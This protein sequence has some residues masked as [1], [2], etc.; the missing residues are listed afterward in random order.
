[1]DYLFLALYPLSSVLVGVLAN[2]RRRNPWIW[3]VIG[4]FL[5]FL[6]LLILFVLPYGKCHAC[7]QTAPRKKGLVKDVA[8]ES[9]CPKC[10]QAINKLEA[11]PA[12]SNIRLWMLLAVVVALPASCVYMQMTARDEANAF[13]ARAV[14]GA[15]L[16]PLSKEAENT[17]TKILRQISKDRVSVGFVGIPPFSR[18]ICTISAQDGQIT[19]SSVSHID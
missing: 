9:I 4:F 14:V 13:C 8:D 18:Y 3:G 5:P 2:R 17:G 11:A 16:E 19:G 12:S 1:M 10:G 7:G 6:P 15:P